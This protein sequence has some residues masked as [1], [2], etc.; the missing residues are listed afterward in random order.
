MSIASSSDRD[1]GLPAGAPVP[2]LSGTALADTWPRRRRWAIL[3]VAAGCLDS[4]ALARELGRR[5]AAELPVPLFV[6]ARSEAELR[7]LGVPEPLHLV[8]PSG[9][10]SR[11][12]QTASTPTAFVLDADGRVVARACPCSFTELE[13]LLAPRCPKD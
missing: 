12:F 7:L 11:A 5:A 2:D 9:E 8:E 4:E 10:L 6:A 13:A 3:F 1:E